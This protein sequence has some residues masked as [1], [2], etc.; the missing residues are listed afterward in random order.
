[1]AG[2]FD[3]ATGI[4]IGRTDAPD[5]PE[6]TQAGAVQRALGDLGLPVLID[7]DPGHQPLQIPLVN[8]ALAD[9]EFVD[10]RGRITQ[11]LVP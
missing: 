3:A 8:G 5:A 10:E 6:L 7:F 1:M 9:V 4:L 11:H 2:W